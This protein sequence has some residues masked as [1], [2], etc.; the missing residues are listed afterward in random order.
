MDRDKEN[1]GNDTGGMLEKEKEDCQKEKGKEGAHSFMGGVRRISLISVGVVGRHKKTKSSGGGFVG[2]EGGGGLP[3]CIPPVL[4]SLPRVVRVTSHTSTADLQRAT[5]LSSPGG[6]D[7]GSG[8][9][10][11]ASAPTTPVRS[12]SSSRHLHTPSISSTKRCPRTPSRSKSKPR[13]S[14]ESSQDVGLKAGL[15]FQQ[16]QAPFSY[17]FEGRDASL[18]KT[19]T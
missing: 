10:I 8:S 2:V 4:T 7:D 9:P 11:A 5:S 15:E 13:K 12:N 16:V 1:K 17:P 3:A 19:P 6:G 14:E 18:L